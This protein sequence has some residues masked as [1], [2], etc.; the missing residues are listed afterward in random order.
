MRA[1]DERQ[2]VVLAHGVKRD[3]SH[4]D[5]LLVA[6]LVELLA[7]VT[8]RV[9][10]DASEQL[11]ARARH[12]VRRADEPRAVRVLADADEKL[13]DGSLDARSVD[14]AVLVFHSFLL[15]CRR[16]APAADT[17]CQT[18]LKRG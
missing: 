7:Q 6:R 11:L 15:E 1:A 14:T 5:E 2:Q 4:D 3:V 16:Q 10:G 8:G 12:A 9:V 17:S 18:N 13:A